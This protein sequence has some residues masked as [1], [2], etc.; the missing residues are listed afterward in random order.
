MLDSVTLCFSFT[1]CLFV[2]TNEHRR[3]YLQG[4]FHNNVVHVGI[5][6]GNMKSR[7]VKFLE[8]PE[9]IFE[10][11]IHTK[12]GPWTVRAWYL[13]THLQFYGIN[14]LKCS[15]EKQSSTQC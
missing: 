6:L 14:K 5:S 2:Y 1:V 13:F 9:S 8:T 3:L 12:L 7:T 10:C 4:E 11:N 15:L